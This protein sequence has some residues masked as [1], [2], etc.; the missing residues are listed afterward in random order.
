[1]FFFELYL[2]YT[3]LYCFVCL[4]VSQVIGPKIVRND[5]DCVGWG[6]K[7]YTNCD[8]IIS[9]R[10]SRGCACMKP[11][12][13]RAYKLPTTWEVEL[14]A[15]GYTMQSNGLRGSSPYVSLATTWPVRCHR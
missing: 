15:I 4:S 7:L 6:V 5:L 10:L 2:V 13:L 14:T 11:A 1:L 8:S 9:C 3:F 12:M